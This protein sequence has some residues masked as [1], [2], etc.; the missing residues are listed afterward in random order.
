M[1]GPLSYTVYLQSLEVTL[2]CCFT[3]SLRV[4]MSEVY[5]CLQLL[6]VEKRFYVSFQSVV[7]VLVKA[8]KPSPRPRAQLC[9]EELASHS[10]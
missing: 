1:C 4:D 2:M 9:V 7:D 6:F 5:D 8:F 3:D 10:P